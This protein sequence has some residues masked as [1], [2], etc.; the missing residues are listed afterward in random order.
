MKH[1]HKRV[2]DP[3]VGKCWEWV[4]D[5]NRMSVEIERDD[6]DMDINIFINDEWSYYLEG[7]DYEERLWNWPNLK[8][9]LE[10][11]KGKLDFIGGKK[12]L[13]LDIV[14][15]TDPNYEVCKYEYDK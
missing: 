9:F 11:N 3:V 12:I 4:V 1:L 5:K 7:I 15:N 6:D 13:D 8:V 14:F 10:K 2:E